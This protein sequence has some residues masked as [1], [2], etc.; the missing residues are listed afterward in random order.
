MEIRGHFADEYLSALF[1]TVQKA[2]VA[3]VAFVKGPGLDTHPVGRGP[4]DQLQSD[5]RL[6]AKHHLV[7]DVVFFRR[8]GSSAQSFGK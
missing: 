6:G 4:V 7:G 2:R 5:L 1:E 8:S 3:A